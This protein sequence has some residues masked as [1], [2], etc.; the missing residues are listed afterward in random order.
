DELASTDP[1][2][3]PPPDGEGDLGGLDKLRLRSPVP[4]RIF[5]RLCARLLSFHS[6]QPCRPASATSPIPAFPS[7]RTIR[8][9]KRT[10]C[11]SGTTLASS[12]VRSRAGPGTTSTSSMTAP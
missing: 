7:A 12:S 2:P 11:A 1:L 5:D 9:W 6:D 10:C 3:Y 8:A 4:R